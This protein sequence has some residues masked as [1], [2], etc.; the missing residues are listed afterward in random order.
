MHSEF[1]KR[2]HN[3]LG[4]P[5]A[6]QIISGLA[7]EQPIAVRSNSLVSDINALMTFCQQHQI[8]Y[9]TAEHFTDTLLIADHDKATL[10]HSDFY[11]QGNAYIQSLASQ[12]PVMLLQPTAH[13]EVLDLCAA[14]GSKTSQMAAIMKNTGRIGAVEKNKARYFKLK[15]N[16]ALLD[17]ANTQCYLKDGT[18]VGRACPNRFDYVLVDAPCSSEGRFNSNDPSSYQYW[19]AKKPKE[20]QRKQWQLIQS[21]FQALKPGGRMVYSTCTYGIEENEWIINK[22]LKRY[23]Q[24]FL[25]PINLPLDNTI[26]GI[27]QPMTLRVLPNALM[28][29]F[30]LAL[31]AKENRTS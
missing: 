20:M 16:L 7:C 4:E 5:L 25:Q 27:E 8:A 30:F 14:P 31:L 13:S 18:S 23:D 6:Q 17:V 10:T 15:D 19:H 2:L 22:L 9:T 12:L 11:N 28:P 21:G 24:A 26:P 29:G 1:I 3:Q